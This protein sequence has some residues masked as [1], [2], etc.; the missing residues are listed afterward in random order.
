MD[1]DPREFRSLGA[2]GIVRESLKVISSHTKL[3][4][5]LTLTLIVPLCF[6][7]L[8]HNLVTEPIT[9]RILWDAFLSQ[10]VHT[11][12]DEEQTIDNDIHKQMVKLYAILAVYA[13]FV[14]AF[15]LLST[16]AVVYSVACIYSERITSCKRV[17]SVVPRVW[18]R[19]IVTFIWAMI[20]TFGYGLVFAF[21]F[22]VLAIVFGL[23]FPESEAAI[24]VLFW[25]GA[26][27]FVGGSVYLSCVWHLG[28]VITVLEDPYGLSAIRKS[29]SLIKG[30]RRTAITLFSVYFVLSFVIG[31]GFDV[32]VV[33]GESSTLGTGSRIAIGALLIGVMSLVNLLGFAVQTIFYFACK[34]YHNEKIDML[35]L[36]DHLGAFLGEY[37]PLRSSIQL[38]PV[39]P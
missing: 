10:H 18:K 12:S 9:G 23:I 21:C 22:T 5:G 37:V 26:F 2:L 1:P 28:S 35:E 38:E 16:S 4:L 19:L 11:G 25:L 3:F 15:S 36:S 34:A 33:R 24:A 29:L 7:G 6:I 39:E 8:G 27:L 20:M 32:W 31:F 17:L 30:K 14:L 13:V